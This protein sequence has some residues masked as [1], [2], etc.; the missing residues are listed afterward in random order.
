MNQFCKT[1]LVSAL[2]IPSIFL[3]P[4]NAQDMDP[5]KK[6]IKT[7]VIAAS[8][9]HLWGKWVS[10]EG[11]QSFLGTE[12]V[13]EPE[14]GGKYE[15]YFDPDEEEGNKGSE[16][17]KILEIEPFKTLSFTWNAPPQFGDLRFQ[18]TKV[19]VDFKEINTYSTQVTITHTD[20]RAGEDWDKVYQ[21]FNEAWAY[22]MDQLQKTAE[23]ENLDKFA[24]LT[25]KWKNIKKEVYEEWSQG[26]NGVMKADGFKIT[27]G[28]KTIL[29][30]ISIKILDGSWQYAPQ[31]VGQNNGNPVYFMLIA[32]EEHKFTF[33]NKDH[34]FPQKISYSVDGD[35]LI[36][37]IAGDMDGENKEIWFGF[38]KVN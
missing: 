25:G 14:V 29:E 26:E 37:T 30:T 36:A 38:R 6:L 21:Y 16:R 20:W 3:T 11:I 15:I 8:A 34:D 23:G 2:M 22:V 19:T 24:Q 10:A 9:E 13:I 35:Q 18:H 27:D 31:V 4:L 12:A 33:E 7:A 17:C 5:E 28:K 32:L 1:L